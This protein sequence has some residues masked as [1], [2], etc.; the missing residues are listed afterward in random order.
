LAEAWYVSVQL[1]NLFSDLLFARTSNIQPDPSNFILAGNFIIHLGNI[2]ARQF[3]KIPLVQQLEVRR[4]QFW[5]KEVFEAINKGKKW[6][7][8]QAAI[9]TENDKIIAVRFLRYDVR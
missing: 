6:D 3:V 9:S 8:A 4:Q 1:H 2:L 5:I 7:E